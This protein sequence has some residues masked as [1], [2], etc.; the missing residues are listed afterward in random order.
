MSANSLSVTKRN[1]GC[2]AASLRSPLRYHSIAEI[3]YILK[4]N[5]LFC[6]SEI[7]SESDN[8]ERNEQ[9]SPYE[10][11]EDPRARGFK[12]GKKY[13]TNVENVIFATPLYPKLK[14]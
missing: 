14:K 5:T 3:K 2:Y 12:S 10:D 7:W 9:G 8:M 11:G 4:G 13:E 1:S 6:L